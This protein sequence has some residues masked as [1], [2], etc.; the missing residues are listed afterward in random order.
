MPF[1]FN[2]H[3]PKSLNRNCGISDR[4]K[5]KQIRKGVITARLVHKVR[6]RSCS[7]SLIPASYALPPSLFTWPHLSGKKTRPLIIHA[8]SMDIIMDI[9]KI[10]LQKKKRDKVK[11]KTGS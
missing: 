6:K 11:Q 8:S 1:H 10:K 5:K 7:V 9:V 2:S 4:K 3:L